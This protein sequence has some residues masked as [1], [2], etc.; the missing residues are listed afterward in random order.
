LHLSVDETSGEILSSVVTANDFKDGQLL[1]DL[2][3]GIAGEIAQVSGDS[4]YDQRTCY[5]LIAQRGARATIPPRKGARIWQHGN[6][7]KPPNGRDVNLRAMR[8]ISRQ[9]WKRDSGYHRRS[10]AETAMSRMKTIFGDRVRARTFDNQAVE[11]HLKCACLNRMTQLGRPDSY[12]VI[13]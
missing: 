11:L 8:R 12:A 6:C 2:L 4:A 10:L 13:V 1:G 3:A 9:R 5:E 7:R